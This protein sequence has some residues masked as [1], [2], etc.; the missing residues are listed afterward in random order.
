MRDAES[1][2]GLNWE[3]EIGSRSPSL[4]LSLALPLSLSL[5]S[6]SVPPG[7]AAPWFLSACSEC[8]ALRAPAAQVSGIS[9]RSSEERQTFVC[10]EIP[11]PVNLPPLGFLFMNPKGMPFHLSRS[12]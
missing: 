6:S 8:A 4:S 3:I 9:T 5:S 7:E 1:A 11:C 10:E 2:E 12:E